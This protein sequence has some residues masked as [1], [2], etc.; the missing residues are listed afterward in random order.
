MQA[1]RVIVDR[2]AVLGVTGPAGRTIVDGAAVIWPQAASDMI[3]TTRISRR[4][5]T[6]MIASLFI[7]HTDG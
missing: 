7:V 2:V 1:V 4:G 3:T 6:C 5:D